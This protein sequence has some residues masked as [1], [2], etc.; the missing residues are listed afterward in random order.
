[1]RRANR[2]DDRKQLTKRQTGNK[3]NGA[4]MAVPATIR[5]TLL[6][7][8][9]GVA[10][11]L[12]QISHPARASGKIDDASRIAVVSSFAP[13]LSV[14][15][16]D[17]KNARTFSVNGIDFFVGQFEGHDVVLFLS[18]ISVVNAAMS[19]QLLLDNFNVEKLVFSGIAGGVNPAL[20]IGDVVVADRW[21]QYFELVLAREVEGGWQPLGFFDYPYSN[22]GMMFPRSVSV[23]RK[24]AGE[25][26]TKFWFPVDSGLFES[27]SAAAGG[28][29]LESCTSENTCLN[30]APRIIVGGSGV[31]G[32]AFVDN[33]EFRNYVFETFE[34]QVLDMESAAI[35]HVAYAND[36]PFLAVRSL[37]DLAGG[38]GNEN[39]IETFLDLA[40]KNAATVLKAIFQKMA[41]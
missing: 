32:S 36:I 19:T 7:F 41:D 14:L 11:S 38:G 29:V 24:G 3:W 13:E 40:A 35:A 8:I 22:F 12:A 27:A 26:E 23:K 15:R 9:L 28:I 21:G 5:G 10:V 25:I 6:A 4:I 30:D 20:N 17:L 37:S 2:I 16:N 1:M 18:G 31:S 33:A 39:Q 34:A